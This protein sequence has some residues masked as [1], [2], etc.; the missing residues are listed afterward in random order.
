VATLTGTETLTNKTLSS[1]TNTYR[2]ASTTVTG[3]S[4]FATTAEYQTGTDTARSL[5]VDQVWASGA[6]TGLTDAAT[7]A[8]DMATGFNFSVTLGGNRTLGNPS[9]T[10]V[11]QTGAF[12]ITQDGAGTRTLAYGTNYEFAGGSA[13]VLSTAIGAKDVL[14]YWVQSSTS[15]VMTGILKAVA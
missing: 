7:I 9:N 6:L 5:V 12:V 11:G 10:K 1:A 4:E 14:F 2:A 3:A 15:I 13:F 8:V